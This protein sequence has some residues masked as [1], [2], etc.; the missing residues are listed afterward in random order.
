MFVF[1]FI[2]PFEKEVLLRGEVGA[3]LCFFCIR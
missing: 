2:L 3:L 1:V